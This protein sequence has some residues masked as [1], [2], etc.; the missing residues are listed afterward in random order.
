MKCCLVY[1]NIIPYYIITK[2]RNSSIS[3]D[4]NN[5]CQMLSWKYIINANFSVLIKS[6]FYT[7]KVH[8]C[9]F[10]YIIITVAICQIHTKK[11]HHI[12]NIPDII[13]WYTTYLIMIIALSLRVLVCCCIFSMHPQAHYNHPFTIRCT[14]YEK[15]I[16]VPKDK[17]SF[18][19]AFSE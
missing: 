10:K 2:Y 11:I 8:A 19:C 16:P 18:F 7:C 14:Q 9:N 12:T 5:T 17:F 1:T 15:P 6:R 13:S 4:M 3:W